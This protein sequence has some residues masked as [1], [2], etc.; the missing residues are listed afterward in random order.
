MGE[1]DGG[2]NLLAARL[3]DPGWVFAELRDCENRDD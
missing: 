1:C 2:H 3:C